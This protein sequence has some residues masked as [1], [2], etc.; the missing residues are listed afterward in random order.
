MTTVEERALAP[1]GGAE[2]QAPSERGVRM[3]TLFLIAFAIAGGALGLHQ[4]HDNSF[5]WHLQTGKYILDHGIPRTDPYSF[6]AQ[7]TTWVAQSWLVEL[8]YG[9]LDRSIGAFGIRLFDALVGGTISALLFYVAYKCSRDRVRAFGLAL[10]SMCV[11]MQ[12]WSERPLLVG[13]LAMMIVVIVCELPDTLVARRPE[14][15][16]PIVMWIW[17]NSH[18][19]FVVGFAYL[20]LHLIGRALDGAPPLQGRERKITIGTA[21]SAVVVFANPY[22]IEL[23]LFPVHLMSRSSVLNNVEEWQSPNFKDIGG[24][25]FGVFVITALVI[26][27]RKGASKR[28]LLITVAFIVLGLWAVRNVGLAVIACLPVLARAVA[29]RPEE[30]RPDVRSS[31]N[32]VIA[33]ALVVVGLLFV[34]RAD[35]Q[36][37]F[38]LKTY[39]VAAFDVIH[40]RGFEGRHLLTT[41]AWGGYVIAAAWPQ[42]HV[43][44]D[45]RYDMYPL[46]V[47]AAYSRIAGVRP[48]WDH[49]LDTYGIDVVMWPKNAALVQALALEPDWSEI[50]SDKT[51]AVFVRRSLLQH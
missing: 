3:S 2:T 41:D 19:T 17:V 21:I 20:A 34:V 27:V 50:Y 32:R 6:S 40:N 12:V 47:D 26:L 18:G 44:F 38:D 30:A 45:D 24:F 29:R 35:H 23:V 10:I 48:G 49:D 33:L 13:L 8:T 39:P 51:A 22:G 5:L 9:A 15:T 16:L 31:M 36:T 28:D 7:G 11:L 43:F 14:I 42:Q 4:L 37:N 1:E 46:S 25:F